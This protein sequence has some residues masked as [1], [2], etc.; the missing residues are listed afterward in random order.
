MFISYTDAKYPFGRIEFE[1]FFGG[2]GYISPNIK[3][4]KDRMAISWDPVA[5]YKDLSAQKYCDKQYGP[6]IK[7]DRFRIHYESGIVIR[8]ITGKLI[9]E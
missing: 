4:S 2:F 7:Q 1:N 5:Y 8:K 3:I 6:V 9:F